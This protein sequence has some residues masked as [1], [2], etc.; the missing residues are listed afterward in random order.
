VLQGGHHLAMVIKDGRVMGQEG[1]Q[2]PEPALALAMPA[3][4]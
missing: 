4:T 3:P 1:V 2:E